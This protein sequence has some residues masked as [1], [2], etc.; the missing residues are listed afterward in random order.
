MIRYQC[1]FV[2]PTKNHLGRKTAACELH[3]DIVLFSS[4]EPAK[5]G[6][7]HKKAFWFCQLLKT[8]IQYR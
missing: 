7:V 6:K 8:D 3:Y 2:L 4:Y 1:Q 5:P